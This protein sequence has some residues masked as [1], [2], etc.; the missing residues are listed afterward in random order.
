MP[1]LFLVFRRFCIWGDELRKPPRGSHAL[2]ICKPQLTLFTMCLILCCFYNH[3]S[4]YCHHNWMILQAVLLF[5]V[6]GC[7]SVGNKVRRSRPDQSSSKKPPVWH[8]MWNP[9]FWWPVLGLEL[10]DEHLVARPHSAGSTRSQRPLGSPPAGTGIGVSCSV[11]QVVGKG[12]D[13]RVPATDSTDRSWRGRIITRW[14]DSCIWSWFIL[15]I[16]GLSKCNQLEEDLRAEFSGG[17]F[18]VLAWELT[19]FL[20]EKLNSDAKSEVVNKVALREANW[21]INSTV[22]CVFNHF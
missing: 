21:W 10:A 11:R 2:P 13:L 20:L 5:G 3:P 4:Q 15:G 17:I 9:P 6:S 14:G 16:G 12:G 7:V 18:I 19:G 8:K 1:A 22:C